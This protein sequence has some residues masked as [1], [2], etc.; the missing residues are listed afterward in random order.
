MSQ[1]LVSIAMPVYNCEKT[2][3]QAIRSILLQTFQDWEFIIINDG[4]TDK[5]M[6]IAQSFDDP[7]IRVFADGEQKGLPMRLN[8]AVKESRGKYIARMDGDDIAYPRRLERQLAYM[9]EHPEV[10]LVGAGILVFG[11]E[12]VALGKRVGGK[13]PRRRSAIVGGSIP[14]AHP[15]FFGKTE[16]FTQN[17]YSVWPKNFQDQ[18]LLLQTLSTSVLRV[19]P[20]I[21]LGYREERLSLRKQIR[22]RLS[23]LQSTRQL[24]RSLGPSLAASLISVQMFKLVLDVFAISTGLKYRVLRHRAMPVTRLEAAEW[25][26]VW[27]AVGVPVRQEPH[28]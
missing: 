18:H 20:E 7:R 19:L 21:L 26:Q 16:W 2:L 25:S 3:A 15:T 11:F 9:K 23:Y 5:T 8:E 24:M 27:Q 10:D 1:P 12:G 13:I 4:S 14:I 17:R 22:Y 6:D 28:F